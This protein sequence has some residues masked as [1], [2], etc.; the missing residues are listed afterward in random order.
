MTVLQSNVVRLTIHVRMPNNDI[1]MNV[2]H[3]QY[4]DPTPITDVELRSD[5][6]PW[7]FAWVTAWKALAGP[8]YEAERATYHVLVSDNN[9]VDAGQTVMGVNG[10]AL[11]DGLPPGTGGLLVRAVINSRGT[12]KKFIIGMT[13]GQ[14]DNGVWDIS[15]LALQSVLGL[16]WETRP[17]FYLGVSRNYEQGTYAGTYNVIK[18]FEPGGYVSPVA[19]YMRRRKQGVGS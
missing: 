9:F 13:E 7:A 18:Y 1:A 4:I 14:Q 16:A 17:D 15:S 5:L 8:D 12:G 19:A 11:T 6:D 3:F 2:F 10:L